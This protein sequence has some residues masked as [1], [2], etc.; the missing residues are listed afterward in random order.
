VSAHGRCAVVVFA[1]APRPGYAKTRLIP[2]LGE[3]GAAHLAEQLLHA[4]LQQAVG[5]GIGPVELCVTP[6]TEHAAFVAA[7][8]RHAIPITEQGDGDLGQRMARAFER[9]LAAQ[10]RALLIGTDAPGLDAGYLRRAARA[11]DDA[12]AVFGPAAD[13]G[14]TLV[15]LK[16]PAPA[17]FS[18]MRWSHDRVMA[19][20]RQRLRASGLRHVELEVLPDVDEPADLIHL[21]QAMRS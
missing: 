3:W 15:G 7:R 14:Y 10:P 5:A 6:T 18:S 12:D 17:L 19:E 20:T 4:T 13:G 16:Q 2:A 21:P 9:V 8:Q 1:K 11:L